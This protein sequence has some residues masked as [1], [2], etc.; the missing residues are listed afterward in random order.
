V[1]CPVCGEPKRTIRKA[2]YPGLAWLVCGHAPGL[3]AH[4]GNSP[5][6][7]DGRST[8]PQPDEEK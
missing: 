8:W 3:R 6:P 7:S 5:E 4:R 2:A 1:W